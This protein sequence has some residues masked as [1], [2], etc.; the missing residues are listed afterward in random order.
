MKKL[1]IEFEVEDDTDTLTFE[2]CLLNAM[3][4]WTETELDK[5][6]SIRT[7]KEGEKC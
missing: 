4:N 1:I 7:K 6:K 2:D 5:C 3:D